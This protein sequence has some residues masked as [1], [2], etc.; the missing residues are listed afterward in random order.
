M[1]RQALKTKLEPMGPGGAW[2][3]LRV[4]FSVEKVFGTRARVPV[5]GRINGVA[6][7]SSLF[8]TGDGRHFMMV[9]KAMQAG[10]EAKAGDTVRVVFEKDTAPRAVAVPRDLKAALARHKQA[11]ARFDRM[12]YS[13][14]KQYVDWITSAKRKETRAARIAKAITM[15]GRGERL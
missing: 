14:Q 9:N 2:T 8:R 12:A 1:T 11:R 13:H 15:I 3:C 4:P 10:A 7:R 5:K 6:F